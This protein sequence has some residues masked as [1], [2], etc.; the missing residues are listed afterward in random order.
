[1]RRSQVIE[2]SARRT[3]AAASGRYDVFLSYSHAAD[4]R[5]APAL[6]RSLRDLAKPWYRR[7]ALRVF[8]DQTSLSATP[9]LWATIERALASSRFFLLLASPTAAASPWVNDEV[10]WWLA[11]RS[12]DSLLIALTDGT[13]AWD[14]RRRECDQERTTALPPVLVAG[15]NDEPLWVDLRWARTEEHLSLRTPGFADAVATLA[16]PLRDLPKDEL[17]GED[18]RQHRR[19]MRVARGAVAIL[20]LLTM[21]ASGLGLLARQQRDQ[22]RSQARLATARYLSAAAISHAT[23]RFDLALLLAIEARRTVDLPAARDALF[24]EVQRTIG[25]S[26]MHC[27]GFVTSLAFRPDGAAIASSCGGS[28]HIWSTKTARQLSQP[29]QSEVQ[30][31][32]YS[33]TSADRLVT[34]GEAVQLRSGSHPERLIASKELAGLVGV[35]RYPQSVAISSDGARMA[36]GFK[37]GSLY[38]YA[39]SAARYAH[40]LRDGTTA[41]TAVLF[42]PDGSQLISVAKDGTVT[43]R[44][45]TT[46]TVIRRV[47]TGNGG[48]A[49]AVSP[50]GSQ[51][52]V[53]TDSGVQLWSTSTWEQV[54][55]A[56]QTG[57]F[58]R[59]LSFQP[60]GQLLAFSLS[61]RTIVWDVH[62]NRKAF[63]FDGPSEDITALAFSPD[64]KSLA[65]G[66][67][68]GSVQ[69]WKNFAERSFGSSLRSSSPVVAIALAPSG[70]TVAAVGTDGVV[71]VWDLRHGR[72]V[73]SWQA[74]RAH[75]AETAAFSPDNRSLAVGG[76][77]DG[78]S[79]WDVRTGRRLAHLD[80]HVT[81]ARLAY[82]P[83]GT[84]LATTA[85]YDDRVTLWN[86]RDRQ[87]AGRL[88]I[89]TPFGVAFSP[90]GKRLAVTGIHL[91]LW[92]VASRSLVASAP[93][94]VTGGLDVAFSPGNTVLAVADNAS[95]TVRLFA[96]GNLVGDHPGARLKPL[97]TVDIA[98]K[99]ESLAFSLDGRSLA[100]ATLDGSVSL[101]DPA[102]RN[103]IAFIRAHS[104]G[105]AIGVAFTPDGRTLISGGADATV[106]MSPID[107]RTLTARACATANRNLTR[108]E[109]SQYVGPV[110]PYEATCNRSG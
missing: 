59:S 84:L 2:A 74:M 41:V 106:L 86:T 98:D 21:T 44:D 61:R 31:L 110:R 81:V 26:I 45:T 39:P 37:D 14:A 68:D 40:L 29:G 89:D 6:Q 108:E 70:G 63:E 92:N 18:V 69:L 85:P 100:T 67:I 107:L 8:R 55:P 51:L 7:R 62:A 36:I 1:M 80:G 60:G 94:G 88:A 11:H 56:V 76:L 38:Y 53:G 101:W 72:L 64:G 65:T 28:L 32:A 19:T 105:R 33:G 12:R 102:S 15:P 95:A 90:D 4:G 109:W 52:A 3:A 13:I 58:V 34:I 25:L 93:L 9:A 66:S 5:L 71:K 43:I 54:R 10:T 82:N 23:E 77:G 50:D 78:V 57:T 104:D 48:E 75:S 42:S 27:G 20:V 35:G 22:A 97:G 83:Q 24:A 96:T 49:A 91:S 46:R 30:N 99:V 16:A 103:R 17:I 47:S 79:I 87:K 73:R